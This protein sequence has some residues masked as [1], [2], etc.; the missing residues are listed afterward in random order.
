MKSCITIPKLMFAL[1]LAGRALSASYSVKNS[2][3]GND[4]FNG[5]T[6]FTGADPTHGLVY[7]THSVIFGVTDARSASDYV[8]KSTA[9]SAGLASVSGG[10]FFLRADSTTVLTNGNGRRSNRITSNAAWDVHVSVY[11]I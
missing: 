10:N 3:V 11:E 1:A 6:W 5:F 2:Y 8:D 4:F 9:Q 7:D